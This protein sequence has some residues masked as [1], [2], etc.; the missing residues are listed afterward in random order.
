[1]LKTK[2]N[3]LKV[4][5]ATLGK[6]TGVK[7]PVAKFVIHIV[8]LWLGMNCRYVFSNM[9]R[10]GSMTEKSYRN[11]FKKF[12]D[13]FGFNFALVKQHAA[14]ELIA[15]FDPSFIGKNGKQTYGLG[16]FWSG[17]RQKALK[18]IEIG[19]LAFIDVTAGTALHGEAVQTPSPKA[20]K[21]NGKTLV[22]HYVEVIEKR[23]IDI[24]SVTRY[25]AVDGYFMKKEFINPLLNQGLQIVTKARSDANLM[26]LFKGKQKTGKGRKRLYDGKIDV[27]NI[28]KRRLACCYRD[29]NMKVYAGVVYCVLLKCTVLAA[30][31]YYGDKPKPEIIVCTDTEMEAMGMCKYYGLRFQVEFLIRDAKQHTGLEDCMA[32]DKE[33]LHTH[34]NIAMTTVS[35]AK[36]AYHLSVPIEQ[37]GSF[38]MADIKMKY[39]NQLIVKRIFSNLALDMSCRKIKRI[40][41][42]CLNFGRLRA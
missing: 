16:M 1:M 26:Y 31:V 7:K 23:I 38:S 9:E 17:T 27:K 24:L 15:V 14:K 6:V 21:A 34:F 22:N 13:W 18:G 35:V 37:R 5:D 10:W 33:K 30:F 41:N 25:L 12:F 3:A 4:V 11:G 40:Y 42:Q 8:E 2:S 32:R 28:D 20:L 36:A 19:C 29:E 39:M